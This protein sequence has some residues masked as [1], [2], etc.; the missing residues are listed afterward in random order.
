M[1]PHQLDPVGDTELFEAEMN[2][3]PVGGL[4]IGTIRFGR[5]NLRID[6]VEDYH[7]LIFCLAGQARV[8]AWDQEA[9]IGPDKGVYL[10]PGTPVRAKFSED[11]EQLVIRVESNVMRQACDGGRPSMKSQIDLNQPA[12]KPW[13]GL[14]QSMLGD[15][16]GIEL[17]R[18]DR[19]LQSDYESMFVRTLLHGHG[20]EEA[21][22]SSIA[23]VAVKRAEAFIHSHLTE[24]LNLD[25]IAGAA[26]VPV[27]TL[28]DS[29]QR[30]RATTPMQFVRDLRLD[31]ARTH[32]EARKTDNVTSIALDVGFVHLGRFSNAYQ[33]RFGERPSE[34]L[35]KA[36]K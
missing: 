23:P 28:L 30:F 7:L 15:A 22:A 11:C 14:M 29:F 31:L 2:F 16:N 32:L 18:T 6:H 5:T 12:L 3:L 13:L 21:K 8:T 26:G 4:G 34:T 17:L 10:A 19:R 20:I 9:S 25:Q 1:Q 35:R 33:A 24:S 36:R 27:R